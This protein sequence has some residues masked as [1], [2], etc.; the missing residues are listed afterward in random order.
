MERSIFA[1]F[2]A[3]LIT[4]VPDPDGYFV[5][6]DD[7]TGPSTLSVLGGETVSLGLAVT[8]F[9]LTGI[10]PI[11]LLDPTDPVAFAAGLSFTGSGT[12]FG[13]VQTPIEQFVPESVPEPS[14]L[15][16]LGLGLT[17]LFGLRR[18]NKT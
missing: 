5:S 3:P 11:L 1:S 13:V 10:A 12:G 7:G 18:R 4:T 6:F 2:T 17:G 14:T 9:E 8:E 16:I 15:G